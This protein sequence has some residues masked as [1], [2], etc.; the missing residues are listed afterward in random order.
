MRTLRKEMCLLSYR[1][2]SYLGLCFSEKALPLGLTI[3]TMTRFLESR[4]FYVSESGIST[5]IRYLSLGKML[6]RL[7][8]WNG[9]EERLRRRSIFQLLHK[10][11]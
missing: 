8:V 6:A 9:N 1:G 3:F 5:S 7:G 2:L 11:V 10:M 4:L